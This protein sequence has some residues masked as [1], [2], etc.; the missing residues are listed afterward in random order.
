MKFSAVCFDI[1]GTMGD[2]FPICIPL[3]TS[4]FSRFGGKNYQDSDVT[5]YFGLNEQGIAQKLTGENWQAAAATFF[6]EYAMAL[7]SQHV[8]PFAGIVELLQALQS[9]HVLLLLVTGKSHESCEIT[10]R[11][12]GMEHFFRQVLCGGPNKL[13]KGAQIASLLQDF[14][15]APEQMCYIGDAL[16]DVTA[17]RANDVVCLSA[18]WQPADLDKAQV[19]ALNPH[20]CFDSVQGLSDFLLPQVVAYPA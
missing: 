12:W 5:Q 10:L 19:R 18:L 8:A 16:T 9:R 1:D 17:C 15:L 20:Y 2:T 3:L 13:N 7:K 6:K 4:I 14:N 11:H